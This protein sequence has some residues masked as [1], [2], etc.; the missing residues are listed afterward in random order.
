MD[1]A[2][3]AIFRILFFD[4]S[5]A[6]EHIL[7]QNNGRMFKSFYLWETVS[8]SPNLVYLNCKK[9]DGEPYFNIKRRSYIT[10][11]EL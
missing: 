1:F 2:M 10:Y 7:L 9:P 8:K 11:D 4:S 3:L 5:S 6:I